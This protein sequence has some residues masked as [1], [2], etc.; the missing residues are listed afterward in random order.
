MEAM[1]K[2][3]HTLEYTVLRETLR[4]ARERAGMS[5]RQLAGILRVP[6]SWVAKVESGERRIDVIE[7][8][9]FLTACGADAPAVLGRIAD[10]CQP[11]RFAA[12][13]RGTR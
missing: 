4:L 12:L 11:S 5:Q 1:Q 10:K 3:V 7:S 6:H 8:C 9:W 13:R 2:S